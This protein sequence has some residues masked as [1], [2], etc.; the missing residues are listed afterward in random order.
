MFNN[1]KSKRGF[2]LVE[3]MVV[4][5]IMG[6]LAAIA[7][8]AYNEY[9]KSAKK[10]AYKADLTSLHKGWLAFG[11]ELDSF[12][13]RETNPASATIAAVGM[14][15]LYSSELYGAERT[16][17][18]NATCITTGGGTT[19]EALSSHCTINTEGDCQ[20]SDCKV[21]TFG[22]GTCA[23]TPYLPIKTT[24]PG[25]KNFIGFGG[26]SCP[27]LNNAARNLHFVSDSGTVVTAND[28]D[29][30]SLGVSAYEMGV[31]GHVSGTDFFGVSITS[32]GV[33][34]GE[35]EAATGSVKTGC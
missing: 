32:S 21:D 25:K 18:S 9:R 11:V 10:S 31:L 2:S 29:D 12:C 5:A 28:M 3:L 17:A 6:T 13:R 4:V 34:Q 27:G 35:N 16:S 24:F 33:L 30:C 19:C 20:P 14:Q 1:K 26:E 8:P 22:T 7:I 15:S 23:F